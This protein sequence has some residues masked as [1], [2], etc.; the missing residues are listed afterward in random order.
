MSEKLAT[1]RKV[2]GKIVIKTY[3]GIKIPKDAVRFN[4]DNEMG[5]Y[6]R[7]GNLIKF[8]RIKELYSNDDF[9]VA[10]DKTGVPGWLAQYDEIVYSGKELENGKVI[11]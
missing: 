6:I 3:S 8:N 7:E 11:D 4:E 10:E 2:T 5:V 9:V 1:L